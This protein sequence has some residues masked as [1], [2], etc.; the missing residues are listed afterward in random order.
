MAVLSK[1]TRPARQNLVAGGTPGQGSRET[2]LDPCTAWSQSPCDTL[3]PR[4][5]AWK[6]KIDHAM[7]HRYFFWEQSLRRSILRSQK[8]LTGTVSATWGCVCTERLERRGKIGETLWTSSSPSDT[9]SFPTPQH[10]R[11]GADPVE[12]CVFP[13]EASLTKVPTSQVGKKFKNQVGTSLP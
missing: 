13:Y 11:A 2:A 3:T 1:A 4:L 9:N 6:H 12:K 10:A 7:C 5:H 8:G